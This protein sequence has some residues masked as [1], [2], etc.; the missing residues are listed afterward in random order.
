M[1]LDVQRKAALNHGLPVAALVFPRYRAGRG[2]EERRL[3]A[4]EALTALCHAKSLLDRQPE[5]FAE[6]LRWIET[7][8]A[9]RLTYG[10]LDRAIEWV[11]LLM[12]AA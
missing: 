9:Y 10:D 3:T 12:S 7:V 4:V 11:L 5:V 1:S 8:P 6:T 2:L